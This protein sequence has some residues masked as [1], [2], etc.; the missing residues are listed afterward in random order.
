[1]F[2]RDRWIE[3]FEAIKKNKLRTFLSGFTVAI[4]IFIFTVLSGMGTGLVN[5]FMSSFADDA[6]NTVFVWGG[7]TSK[8]YKG[9]P[10]NRW[11]DLKTDDIQF[12][13]DHY[14][15]EIQYYSARLEHWIIARYKNN[16]GR[17]QMRAVH[18]QHQIL[19]KTNIIKG[20]YI[21]EKDLEEKRKV[22]VI[23]RLSEKDLFKK[24]NALG[25]HIELDGI[26]Y[27]VVGVFQDDG[28][29]RE[30]RIIYLPLTTV[31]LIYKEGENIDQINFSYNQEMNYEQAMAFTKSFERDL[32][33]RH[34]VHS[35]DNSAVRFIVKAEQARNSANFLKV[36]DLVV[37]FISI[38]T[39]IAGIVGISNIMV[40]SVKERTKELGIRKALGAPPKSIVNLVLQEAILI[41]ALAGYGG[42]VLGMLALG[43]IGDNLENYFITDPHINFGTV[44]M[45]TVILIISGGIAGYLPARRASRIKPIVALR[46]K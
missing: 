28:G 4:G 38:G 15:D 11:I 31:Q 44:I 14:P 13:L 30:E 41:T 16:G 37:L 24:K 26:S 42:M 35:E 21:N 46:D 19:E 1:M 8:P 43:G 9:L 20:R 10:E 3:I 27:Q 40:F 34:S 2:D 17:Y 12:M 39:L 25:K 6:I 23:G 7:I 18:P 5:T 36:I 22:A 33:I 45:A 29:D 32:K